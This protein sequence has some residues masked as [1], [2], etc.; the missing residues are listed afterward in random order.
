MVLWASVVTV[1]FGGDRL[2][3]PLRLPF[4]APQGFS[5]VKTSASHFDDPDTG[6]ANSVL[7][8]R[9]YGMAFTSKEELTEW[10]ELQREA[11][12]RDHRVVGKAQQLF[13][14]HDMS[15]G[16]AFMLP[17]GT[18]VY[19]KLI[20]VLRDEYRRQGYDEVMSPLL[21]K[22]ELWK[23][24]GHWDNYRVRGYVFVF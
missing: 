15:P 24:S 12:R 2:P 10:E 1:A 4:R 8:H 6:A 3:R 14:F 19:N 11:Q 17:H 5:I 7:L 22:P 21:Y 23:T 13:M 18:R 16:S 20:D 9:L